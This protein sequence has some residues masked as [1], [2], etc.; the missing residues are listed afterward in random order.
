[1]KPLPQAPAP[2]PDFLAK[3]RSLLTADEYDAFV[4]AYDR[5]PVAGLRVNTLK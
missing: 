1:M 3:M 5:P 4:A 2:P